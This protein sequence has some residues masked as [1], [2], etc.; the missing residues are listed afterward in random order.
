MRRR[1]RQ[2][3]KRDYYLSNA[4]DGTPLLEFVRVAKAA[5]RIEEC[6]ERGKGEAGMADYEVR[7]W[8]GWQHHQTLSLLAAWF[9]TLETRRGEKKDAC[10][11]VQSGACRHRSDH[12]RCLPMR[13]PTHRQR[14]HRET[15]ETKPTRQT[16]PLE[17]I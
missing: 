15:P 7:N 11:Y 10:H 4:P 8:V 16:L 12:P 14:P 9:L 17:T 1:D 3:V 13:L 5:H 6:F 2:I